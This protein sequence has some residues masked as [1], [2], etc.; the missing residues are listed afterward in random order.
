VSE[1]RDRAQI[2]RLI[3]QMLANPHSRRTLLRRGAGGALGLGLAGFLAACGGDS[4]AG[5]GKA[6]TVS[7]GKVASSMY[8]SN[9]PDYIDEDHAPLKDFQKKFGTK[10]KYIEDINDND[11]FFGKVRP[12]LQSGAAGGRDLWALTDWMAGRMIQLNYVQK[13]DKSGIPNVTNNLIDALKHPAFDPNRDFSAPWQS[14]MTGLIYRTDKMA[15]P[16]SVNEI[17]NP[18]WKGK[19]TMLT[20]MRDTVGLT[21]LGMG[22][23]PAKATLDQANQALDKVDK[24]NRDGQIRRFTGND[25]IRD[26]PKGDSWLVY[27]WSGDGVQL[28]AGYKNIT[29]VA[30]KEGVML[31]ADN[32]QIPI[33]AP[34]AWTAETFMNYI[35][36]PEVQAKIAAYI[37]YITPVKGVKEVF[38]K[39][40][41]ELADNQLIF[42]NAETLATT[43]IFN[44]LSPDDEAKLNE[45]FQQIIGA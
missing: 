37:Q 11:Q 7:K 39:T 40:H 14:G 45:R 28:E 24:A 43:H 41:P 22:M 42:P 8:F 35:Y 19:V 1:S 10:V 13:L 30:P 44:K 23:D 2:E 4:G 34:H 27:G 33:G 17:F 26:L 9:W 29:Y 15:K 3:D 21:M 5:G 20:E 32:M 25:Y 31:W 16:E 38:Q 12:L 36:E 6:Q 18:K